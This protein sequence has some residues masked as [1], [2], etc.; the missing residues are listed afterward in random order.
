MT[1][2]SMEGTVLGSRKHDAVVNCQVD[3]VEGIE[4]RIPV[5]F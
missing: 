5:A 1:Y 4:G 3:V 2:I